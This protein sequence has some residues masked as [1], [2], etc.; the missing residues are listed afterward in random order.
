MAPPFI[1]YYG[2]ITGNKSLMTQG[3]TQ[4]SLYRD[5]LRDQLSSPGGAALWEHIVMGSGNDSGH[6][7]TGNGWAAAGMLRVHGTMANSQF[8]GDS[9]VKSMMG[10][11]KNWVD[12]IFNG[13]YNFVVRKLIRHC[14]ILN[15]EGHF[16]LD[17]GN[18]NHRVYFSTTSTKAR[19]IPLKTLQAQ[20]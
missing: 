5:Q 9:D 7:S 10:D 3:Y 15:T 1:A 18:S 12:E 17:C 19:Q 6:W 13:M 20:L 11:L 2:A 16:L 8:S 14:K 4:I